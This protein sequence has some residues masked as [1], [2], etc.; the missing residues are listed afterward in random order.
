MIFQRI[1]SAG[2]AHNSYF[3][4]SGSQAA[5]IAPQRQGMGGCRLSGDQ[6]LDLK[7]RL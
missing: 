5:V 2:I 1:K 6:R 7:C 4:G 3:I